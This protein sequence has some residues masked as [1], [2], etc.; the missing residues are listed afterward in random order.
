MKA[1]VPYNSRVVN[2]TKT[3]MANCTV[4]VTFVQLGSVCF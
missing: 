1:Q 3:Q 2:R 4:M